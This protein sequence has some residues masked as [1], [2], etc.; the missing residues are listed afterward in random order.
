LP[1]VSI[2]TLADAVTAFLAEQGLIG[3]GGVGSSMSH[4]S[5]SNSLGEAS[6]ETSYRSTWACFPPQAQR[7]AGAF[8]TARLHWFEG[9][10]HFPTWD[11]PVETVRPILDGGLEAANHRRQLM[12]AAECSSQQVI[13]HPRINRDCGG[14]VSSLPFA[15]QR[16]PKHIVNDRDLSAH[17][18]SIAG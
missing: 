18:R 14:F 17:G 11:A 7:V 9:S 16:T 2:A 6:S 1:D 3:S 5:C 15:L 4:D 13:S 10:G 12:T 8:P